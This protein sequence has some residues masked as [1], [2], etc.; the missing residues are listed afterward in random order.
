MAL[1]DDETT[2]GRAGS[3]DRPG[4]PTR[5]E[6]AEPG[7]SDAPDWGSGEGDT[8]PVLRTLRR[9][10]CDLRPGHPSSPLLDDGT[11]RPDEPSLK[12]VELP[13]PPLSD[14]DW[15]DHRQDF[16]DR[17]NNAFA[18]GLSTNKL[19]TVDGKG[20]IWT[21]E[22]SRLHGLLLSEAYA[23]AAHVPCDRLAIMVGG[24]GG[25]GKTTVLDQCAGI[26]RSQYLTIN[27][28]DF[29]E[30]LA[31]RGMLPKVP[32]L[33]PMEA[34]AL[35][36]E[37]ASYLAGHLARRALADGK[38]VIWDITMSSVQTT[39]RRM[40]ELRDAGYRQVDAIYVDVPV[41]FSI[42]RADVRHR[43][44]HDK[45]L[46]GVG[47]GGRPLLADVTRAQ[48]DPEFGIVNRRAFEVIKDRSDHWA[49]FDNSVTGRA[50]ALTDSGTG[51]RANPVRQDRS[52][53]DGR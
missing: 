14:A 32:G 11:P 24:L 38:N 31:R 5:P 50:A 4:L 12:D 34:S 1:R 7:R 52:D 3:A 23:N 29:K 45:Y 21:A 6:T 42:A 19:C 28:D 43:R 49:V 22:R 20:Q 40:D 33:S 25:A 35:A 48:A 8:A 46:A 36:H 26:D 13:E 39:S 9:R 17:L 10:A 16:T 27:P 53:N 2:N 15:A 37:E 47:L 41:E 30:A 44:G 18:E 51:K